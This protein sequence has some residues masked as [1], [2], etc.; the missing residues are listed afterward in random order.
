M[1]KS[2]HNGRFI[3]DNIVD[4]NP[5]NFYYMKEGNIKEV[6]LNLKD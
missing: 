5:S 2:A 3:T 4:Y 6:F 1:F